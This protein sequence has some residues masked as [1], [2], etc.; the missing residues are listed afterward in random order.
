MNIQE[1][2]DYYSKC[3]KELDLWVKDNQEEVVCKTKQRGVADQARKEWELDEKRRKNRER[4]RKSRERLK[5]QDELVP[6]D[7]K[8][9]EEKRE[10]KRAQWRRHYSKHQEKLKEKARDRYHRRKPL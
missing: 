1:L 10:Q 7:S 2:E 6:V 4:K 3:G 8:T 5:P 9:E